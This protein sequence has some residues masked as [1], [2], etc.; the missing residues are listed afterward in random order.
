MNQ[1][2]TNLSATSPLLDSPVW[3]A[4]T[5]GNAALAEGN[6]LAMRYPPEVAPF[7]A[8]A[9]ETP[10]SFEAL[11]SLTSAGERV[12]LVGLGVLD[13]PAGF[14]I[15]RQASIVQMILETPA[16]AEPAGPE[17]VVLGS[18]DVA[19]MI[20]LTGRTRPGPFGPRTIE[21]GRYIGIRADGALAAMAGERMRFDRFVEI[22]AVCVDPG[23]RGKGYAALLMMR[24]IRQ[25]QGRALTPILHVFEDNVNA[26]SLYERLG[27][28]WRKTMQLTV[29]ARY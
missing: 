14:R 9:G 15:E 21:F 5:T 7:A 1:S 29:L 16:T 25:M 6:S 8:V 12:A 17:P 18:A 27:F 20:D 24:L 10:A 23:H 28:R 13:P 11:A 2:S 22:S 26:I 4:L 19:D 3:A